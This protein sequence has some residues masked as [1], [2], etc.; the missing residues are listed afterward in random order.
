[1]SD[2]QPLSPELQLAENRLSSAETKL[3]HAA[4]AFYKAEREHGE[5]TDEEAQL[6]SAA[7]EYAFAR[8]RFYCLKLSEEVK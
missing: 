8:Y 7:E 2:I 3:R 4:R 6:Y 1:M 5:G